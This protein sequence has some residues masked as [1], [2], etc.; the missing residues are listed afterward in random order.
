MGLLEYQPYAGIGSRETPIPILGIMTVAAY[1][2]AKEGY[3]LRSGGAPGA[4]TAFEA[5]AWSA[6]DSD[7]TTKPEIYLPWENFEGR[8]NAIRV[9]PQEEAFEIAEKFHPN[10]NALSDGGKKLQARNV[11]QVLGFNVTDPHVSGFLIC[12]TPDAKGGGGTGQA[13]RIAKH[14]GVKEVYDLANREHLELVKGFIPKHV[15]P[16]M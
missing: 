6:V 14:Y 13:L 1:Y 2:L 11:H 7:G 5:G 15:V 12:Y 16:D 3:T 8:N 9:E 4:D 10:W